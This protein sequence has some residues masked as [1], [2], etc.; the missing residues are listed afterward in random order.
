MNPALKTTFGDLTRALAKS[1][2]GG[3]LEAKMQSVIEHASE[4]IAAANQGDFSGLESKA[5][6]TGPLSW[7][8]SFQAPALWLTAFGTASKEERPFKIPVSSAPPSI[9]TGQKGET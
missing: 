8:I 3:A 2:N 6:R 9:E 5:A 7:A 1:L 4:Q